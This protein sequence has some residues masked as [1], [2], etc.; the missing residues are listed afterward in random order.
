MKKEEPI[1]IV[2]MCSMITGE[3][4]KEKRDPGTRFQPGV[5][6]LRNKREREW[7]SFKRTKSGLREE[8]GGEGIAIPSRPFQN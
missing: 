7:F 5:K 4:E 1:R 3:R 2:A 6:G 8:E